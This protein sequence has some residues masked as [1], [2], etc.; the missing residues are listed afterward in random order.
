MHP[1]AGSNCGRNWATSIVEQREAK[2]PWVF[3]RHFPMLSLHLGYSQVHTTHS[4]LAHIIQFTHS[5]GD[6]K[7]LQAQ[8][9]WGGALADQKLSAMPLPLL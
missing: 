8:G 3:V 9:G 4:V 2:G 1:S 7:R 6:A 5:D